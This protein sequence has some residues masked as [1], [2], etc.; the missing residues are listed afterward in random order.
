VLNKRKYLPKGPGPYNSILVI[1]HVHKLLFNL[2]LKHTL[3]FL[4]K[5]SSFFSA[6]LFIVV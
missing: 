5:F 3:T 1:N 4:L 2:L 6:S